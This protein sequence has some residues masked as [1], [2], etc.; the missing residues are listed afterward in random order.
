MGSPP[1]R[2]TTSG[3]FLALSIS[4][5]VDELLRGRQLA[6]AFAD[7]DFF[8]LR[9]QL[10]HFRRHQGVVQHHVGL[11]QQARAAQRDEVLGAGAG[12]DQIDFSES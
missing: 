6:A 4:L 1:L 2:R 3:N 5:L 9:A 10:Q 8:G 7:Q 11:R 12:A